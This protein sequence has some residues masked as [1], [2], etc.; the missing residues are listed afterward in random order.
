MPDL[1][2]E[3]RDRL[4]KIRKVLDMIQENTQKLYSPGQ[5]L[6]ADESLVPWKGRRLKFKQY[7]PKKRCVL[8]A[9]TF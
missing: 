1:D 6:S 3:N 7:I 8:C 4:F 9:F 5:K 2:D